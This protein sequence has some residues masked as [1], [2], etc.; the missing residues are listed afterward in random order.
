MKGIY[1]PIFACIESNLFFYKLRKL[2]I[3]NVSTIFFKK[4][5]LHTFFCQPAWSAEWKAVVGYTQEFF[6]GTKFC[7]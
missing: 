5:P 4:E 3:A 2:A 1:G 7:Y 6:S